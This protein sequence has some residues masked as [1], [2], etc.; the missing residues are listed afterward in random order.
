MAN[1]GSLGVTPMTLK[2]KSGVVE[3]RR[4]GGVRTNVSD[5]EA[6]RPSLVLEQGACSGWREDTVGAGMLGQDPEPGGGNVHAPS[7][8]C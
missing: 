2:M 1:C 4:C 7:Q 5:K 3:F 6:R 8:S